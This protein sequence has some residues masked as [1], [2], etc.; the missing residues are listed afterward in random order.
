[1]ALRTRVVGDLHGKSLAHAFDSIVT[2]LD[3]PVEFAAEVLADAQDSAASPHL[4]A[5]DRTDLEFV[6]IDPPGSMDLDQALCLEKTG[7]GMR[8]HYAIADVAAFVRPGSPTDQEARRRG[9]TLYAVNQRVPLHPQVLSEGAASLLPG[10]VR[11][12]LVWQIDVDDTGTTTAA[13]V[14]RAMVRSRARYSYAEVQAAHESGQIPTP[15]ELLRPMGELLLAAEK[16]R[17][18]AALKVPD[19]EIEVTESGYELVYRP[20]VGVE[21]WNAQL[22]LLTGR[23]AADIMITGGVGV[24]RT[25]PAPEATTIER[26]RR[27]ALALGVG[28]PDGTSYQQWLAE[29]D[30]G[31]PRQLALSHESSVLFR[32]ARYVAFDGEPPAERTQAAVADEYAHVTA[33]LRRLVDRFGLEVC[34]AVCAGEPVPDWVREAL[35]TLPDAMSASDTMANR[36]ER[37]NIDLAEAALLAGRV[38]EHFEGVIVDVREANGD[39]AQ[40][41]LVQL[42]DPAVLARIDG[43]LEL[44]SQVQVRLVEADVATRQVRF[45]TSS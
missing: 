33:P 29:L 11:P 7:S 13:T 26:L 40:R 4:P 16:S 21:Q 42:R 17:G 9:Q 45:A 39:R 3:A 38:G 2:E 6:T 22:S 34:A 37:A 36:I 8:L 35:P 32:G 24:L 18:G 23:A 28:W 12:A 1:M 30:P 14:A 41:G 31:D 44:G 5:T 10:Q 19:Q 27:Q 20:L 15:F 43:N 25:M